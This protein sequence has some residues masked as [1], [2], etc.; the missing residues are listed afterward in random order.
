MQPLVTTMDHKAV[1]DGRP[2]PNT[3]GMGAISPSPFVTP[4]LFSEVIDTIVFPTINRMHEEGR[5][6]QG[7]S[8]C[9]C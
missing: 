4:E 2:G 1:Y 8:L 6:L 3:G 7:R 5:E 9:R